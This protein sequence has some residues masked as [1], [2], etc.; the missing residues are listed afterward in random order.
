M[1]QKERQ[2]L[3]LI[4][5]SISLRLSTAEREVDLTAD[6]YRRLQ[7]LCKKEVK[8]YFRAAQAQEFLQNLEHHYVQDQLF[9][10]FYL[11]S[12][13]HTAHYQPHV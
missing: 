7:G 8:I 13:F 12:V 2:L 4:S 5:W 9:S 3:L 6:S 1:I 10:I 11:W